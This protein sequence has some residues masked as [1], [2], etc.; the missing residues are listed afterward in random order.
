MIEVFTRNI[1]CYLFYRKKIRVMIV[2]YYSLFLFL[3]LLLSAF[4]FFFISSY[5]LEINSEYPRTS[6]NTF[7]SDFP[8]ERKFRSRFYKRILP[9]LSQYLHLGQG[10]IVPL[11]GSAFS[12]LFIIIAEQSVLRRMGPR[13]ILGLNS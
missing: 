9:F 12:D 11:V 1:Y 13:S 8:K 3:V 6:L 2:L 4:V 7:R 5:L 10:L